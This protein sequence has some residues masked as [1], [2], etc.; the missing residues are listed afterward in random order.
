MGGAGVIP[1]REV[2]LT[3]EWANGW[4]NRVCFS[5]PIAGRGAGLRCHGGE[6]A[7]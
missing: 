5:R 7:R 3:K 4:T 6:C 2:R 1:P